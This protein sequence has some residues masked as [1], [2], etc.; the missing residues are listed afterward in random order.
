MIY[1]HGIC[2]TLCKDLLG[3]NVS[4]ILCAE[5]FRLDVLR[6]NESGC[7]RLENGIVISCWQTAYKGQRNYIPSLSWKEV[8]QLDAIFLLSV[9]LL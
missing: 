4:W 7:E 5:R 1:D 9:W 2:G 8:L 6:E 3:S